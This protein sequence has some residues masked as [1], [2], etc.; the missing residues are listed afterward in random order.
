MSVPDS[1]ATRKPA[2][3]T[4]LA[5]HPL[6]G[7]NLKA[8]VDVQLGAVVV[9]GFRVIQQPGQRAWVSPPQREW[10]ADGR[11]RFAPVIELSGD[12]KRRV[13]AA[14]LQAWQAEEG[15]SHA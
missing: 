8:F 7:S 13:E 10:M 4:I 5:I 12:L 3:I 6:Q 11:K 14:I 1:P 9:H 2:V 15:L